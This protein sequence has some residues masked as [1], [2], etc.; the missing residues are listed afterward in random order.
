MEV[1]IFCSHSLE[2][3]QEPWRRYKIEVSAPKAEPERCPSAFPLGQPASP[4]WDLPGSSNWEHQRG[5]ISKAILLHCP[6]PFAFVP[7][8]KVVSPSSLCP[9]VGKRSL[10]SLSAMPR[11][12]DVASQ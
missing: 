8:G 7:L 3:Q 9:G 12:G 6:D 11:A 2:G 5:E 10:S 1:D 4:P